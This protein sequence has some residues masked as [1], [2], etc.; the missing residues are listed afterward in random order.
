MGYL[1]PGTLSGHNQPLGDPANAKARA[2]LEFGP[3]AESGPPLKSNIEIAQFIEVRHDQLPLPLFVSHSLEVALRYIRSNVPI[4]DVFSGSSAKGFHENTGTH[5]ELRQLLRMMD[6]YNCGDPELITS[7]Y[8]IGNVI[9]QAQM[10]GINPS[11]PGDLPR[12]F[13]YR[14]SQIWT[15]SRVAWTIAAVPR[16]YMLRKKGY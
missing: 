13:D 15:N 9:L 2:G 7:G 1:P 4:T 8:N 6:L 12:S 10:L 3:L 11:A 5:G 14:S 16:I